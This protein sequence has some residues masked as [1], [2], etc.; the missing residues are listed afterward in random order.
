MT[1]DVLI[2]GGG[3]AGYYAAINLAE[4]NPKL[5]IAILEKG[6]SVL[7]KVRI[8]G[9]GR[10]NVTHAEFD[11][12]VFSQN[13]PR[14]SRELR[15][16][17]H[18]HGAADT[19]AFFQN[20]GIAL[21]TEDD[22]RIFPESNTSE[23]IVSYF[24][25]TAERLGI[26]LF[27]LTSVQDIQRDE[28]EDCW[29]LLTRKKEFRGKQLLIASGSNYKVWHMLQR[30]GHTLVPPVPSLFTFNIKDDRLTGLQGLSSQAH[31]RIEKRRLSTKEIT[32][33]LK[34]NLRAK[35]KLEAEG[36]VLITHWGLS[37]PAVLRLSAIGARALHD[38]SYRFRI[39]VNWLPDYHAS[40]L[41]ELL[42]EIKAVESKKTILRTQ[43]FDLPRKLWARLVHAAGIPADLRWAHITKNQLAALCEQLCNSQFAVEGKSTFKEEFVTAGGIDL[44]EIDFKRFGSKLL[45]NLYFAGEVLDVD[46]IT[47]GFN[48]QNAWTG[49]YVAAQAILRSAENQ[50]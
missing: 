4:G 43:A 3:A 2:V 37:G 28:V 30:L 46:G 13:Y 41:S 9:G 7:S 14:G 50:A 26:S 32:V 8:S 25:D 23:T 6:K 15:G 36:P 40:S 16:P 48:F 29:L 5:N 27:R 31:I 20:R 38:Y 18:L 35:D 34:S 45:P 49:A 42:L 1:Y 17:M 33:G 10:C 39:F 22:G 44:R 47:G 12:A 19:V 24:T 11:P 21:K